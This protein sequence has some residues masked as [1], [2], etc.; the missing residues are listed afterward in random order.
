[1]SSKLHARG[2][3]LLVVTC[4]A[5]A[6]GSSYY[7][8]EYF[9]YITNEEIGKYWGSTVNPQQVIKMP[10]SCEQLYG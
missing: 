1:M 3:L 6:L 2:L 8:N 4:T 5:P 10:F 7:N 9:P